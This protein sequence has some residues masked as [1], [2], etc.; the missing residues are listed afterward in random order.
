MHFN[1]KFT[2]I[3][4]EFYVYG[5]THPSFITHFPKKRVFEKPLN[6]TSVKQYTPW[7]KHRQRAT[8]QNSRRSWSRAPSCTRPCGR[9][10]PWDWRR[11]RDTRSPSAPRDRKAAP[12]RAASRPGPRRRRS[13]CYRCARAAGADDDSSS[14]LADRIAV[15]AEDDGREDARADSAAGG[16][17]LCGWR[18]CCSA[19]ASILGA[20]FENIEKSCYIILLFSKKNYKRRYFTGNLLSLVKQRCS[21]NKTL[22]LQSNDKTRPVAREVYTNRSCI[23]H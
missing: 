11:N 13:H 9:A 4:K 10:R 6:I 16:S 21:R 17:G 20:V 14:A 7:Y 23:P 15:A 5:P 19:C 22:D 2:N 8:A 3:F 18:S 12:R 1:F